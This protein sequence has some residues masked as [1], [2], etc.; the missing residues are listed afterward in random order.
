[1]LRQRNS[2]RFDRLM[3]VILSMLLT[4]VLKRGIRQVRVRVS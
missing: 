2:A 3:V 1:M 4:L